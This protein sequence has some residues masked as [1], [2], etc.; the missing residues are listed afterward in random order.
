MSTVK[1]LHK[2]E[3]LLSSE[4]QKKLEYGAFL[5]KRHSRILFKIKA[6][7]DSKITIRTSQSKSPAENYADKE[8]LIQRTRELFGKFLPGYK[9][10]VHPIEYKIPPVD[11]ATPKWISQHMSENHIRVKDIANLTGIDDSNISAWINDLRPMSQPVK[12]MFYALLT[13][14]PQKKQLMH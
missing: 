7:N 14:E 11:E 3:H 6:V 9:I 5:H 13:D 2:I 12:A 8:R 10:H 1:N 4:D